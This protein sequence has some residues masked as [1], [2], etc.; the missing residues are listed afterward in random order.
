MTDNT[1]HK[2]QSSADTAYNLICRKILDGEFALGQRLTRREMAKMTGVSIIPVIEALH[3][4]EA[5]GLVESVP[6]VGSRV[7]LLTDDVI[8]DR[9]MLR[10]AI[11]CQ[12]MRILA[13]TITDEQINT[14]QYLAGK[15][16]T[17]PRDSEYEDMFWELHYRFHATLAEYSN[18]QSLIKTLRR[19]NLFH[20]L[21]RQTDFANKQREE[22]PA[23][24][25]LRI[26]DAIESGNPDN[27]EGVIRDHIERSLRLRNQTKN[28]RNHK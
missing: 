25:H 27:A 17:T 11:E 8:W 23:N 2:L 18:S 6:H 22:F 9:V 4:L 21:Q 1:V 10:E 24:W 26:V 5:E 15:L 13:V 16:D 19:I 7:V 12:I 20:I 14:L 3:R 28:S